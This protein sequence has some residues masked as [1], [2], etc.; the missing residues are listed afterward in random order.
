MS[1]AT[2]HPGHWQQ[3]EPRRIC[4][5]RAL[6]LGDLI[7]AG[8]ALRALRRRFPHAHITLVGLRWSADFVQRMHPFIDEH[9]E[10]PG[11]PGL[12]ERPV[13]D[14]AR[15]AFLHRMRDSEF[16]L[17]IQLQGSG[18]LSN[19]VVRAFGARR[20]AAHHPQERILLSATEGL[21]P[22]PEQLHE[23]HRNLH[24]IGRLG[25]TGDD[26][27]VTF[28]LMPR[29]QTELLQRRLDLHR[30]PSGGYVCLHPGARDAAKRWPVECFAAIG[31]AL[32][33]CGW[34][35]VI[36]GGETEQELA[37][38]VISTM[39]QP[40]LHAA[41]DISIGALSVLLSRARLLISNDTGVAHIA[42]ALGLPSVVVFFATDPCRWAPLDCRRHAVVHDDGPPPVGAVLEAALHL[43][44]HRTG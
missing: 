38:R 34:I 5:L 37:A 3:L 19:D 44:P 32:A 22:Y 13:D 24:L 25:A 1:T 28:P 43:L 7:C 41:C 20:M 8:P 26:D 16:D 2:P 36:T 10:F 9:V 14:A 30:L 11:W 35:V 12:P 42:A 6:Q 23:I 15:T 27:R 21:W 18:R 29:D 17:A 39:H 31:D 4:V 40:A 33:S